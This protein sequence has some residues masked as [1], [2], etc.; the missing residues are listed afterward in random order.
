M[1]N[2]AWN[3]SF[4]QRYERFRTKAN[5]MARTRN[6]HDATVIF[7]ALKGAASQHGLAG[8]VSDDAL[9]QGAHQLSQ[10]KQPGF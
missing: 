6:G 10:G 9:W 3:T 7:A 2:P 1:V 5:R 4:E 8:F